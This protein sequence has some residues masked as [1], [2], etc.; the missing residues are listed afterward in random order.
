MIIIIIIIIIIIN[1]DT[2][3]TISNDRCFNMKD[4]NPKIQ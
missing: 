2:I 4:L 3:Y 1:N